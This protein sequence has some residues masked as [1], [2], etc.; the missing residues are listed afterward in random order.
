M[1]KTV[2][3]VIDNIKVKPTLGFLGVG[4]I[5]IN[6]LNALL[7]ED[8][9]NIGVLAD[10]SEDSLLKAQELVP[11]A[12]KYLTLDEVLDSKPDG[13]VIATPSALHAAQALQSLNNGV[14]V[15][16]QKP[17]T[18]TANEAMK[19]V[20]A[21]EANNLL[22]GVD[23]SYRFTEG[24]QI[25]NQLFKS[26]A[27][28]E[29]YAIDLVF[30]N[31]YG[32]DKKWFYNPA[33]SGGGCMIDLGSHLIDLALWMLDFPEVTE[34]SS[35]LFS[36]G[37][38][39]AIPEEETEDYGLATLQTKNGTA[40][41][42]A[43]SWNLQAGQDAIIAATFYGTKGGATFRNVEGSFYNFEA[44]KFMAK[45]QR[46]LLAKPDHEDWGGR[47]VIDWARKI[48]KGDGFSREAY[49]YVKVAEIID[50]IYNKA[51]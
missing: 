20:K 39:I 37:K 12:I 10:N 11:D 14:A 51:T 7:K 5:G 9:V 17:L 31:A 30:H 2:T 35:V 24:M 43:C 19:V 36:Q 29:I 25:I 15:F 1:D 34:V 16:C 26:G 41:Q 4:W 47:A 33:M 49:Q 22:L 32:P 27:F 28:G 38:R 21:A 50:R 48:S 23:F 46:E 42:L 13:I 8:I 6:R 3:A 40:I 18:L 44:Y 45:T